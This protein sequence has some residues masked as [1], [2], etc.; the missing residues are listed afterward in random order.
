MVYK[1]EEGV[2]GLFSGSAIVAPVG[3]H[4]G[5]VVIDDA[6]DAAAVAVAVALTAAWVR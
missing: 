2:E 4:F 3:L 5:A 6:G 1:M